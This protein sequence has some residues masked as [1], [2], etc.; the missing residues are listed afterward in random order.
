MKKRF[1]ILS[2][3]LTVSLLIAITCSP[4]NRDSHVEK[5]IRK[6]ERCKV[7]PS[8]TYEIFI[9]D[10]NSRCSDLPLLV[11]I[12]PQGDSEF[13]LEKF[14]K[15]AQYFHC[16]ILSTDKIKN[17][18][19]EYVSI[20]NTILNDVKDKYPVD[21]T[22]FL[23]GFSGGARMAMN[24]AQYYPVDGIISCGAL[25]TSDQIKEIHSP[26]I[27][28][29]GM[30]DFNFIEAAQYVFNPE[31]APPNLN[32]SFTSNTHEWP[33]SNELLYALGLLFLHQNDKTICLTSKKSIAAYMKSQNVRFDSLIKANNL[34]EAGLLARN[35]AKIEKTS[36]TSKLESI[37]Y[38]TNFN[39]EL[40]RLR[41]SIRFELTVRNA[42]Y[43][44]LSEENQKWWETE[45][46]SLNRSIVEEKDPYR[47]F[48]LLRIKGYLGIMCYS[49]CNNSLRQDDMVAAER[50]L[51]IYRIIEPE[52]PDMLYFSALFAYKT[53]H[54][55]RVKELLLKA[56]QAGFTDKDILQEDFPEELILPLLANMS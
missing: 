37:E 29:A 8:I 50:L 12:D 23:A 6:T 21:E 4:D 31:Q 42:Y 11:S 16:I 36:F 2:I 7:S 48:A 41:E 46:Y 52:N 18:S 26:I 47:N 35:L 33:S 15:A 27:S 14:K 38:N 32:L 53:E 3:I 17:R 40:N 24:Y 43:Q 28:V 55:D 45:I 19:L 5:S 9:P 13:A 25:N 54:S 51:S 10:F 20:L 1:S 34:F 56:I 44:A 39:N 49:L 22:I 30:A